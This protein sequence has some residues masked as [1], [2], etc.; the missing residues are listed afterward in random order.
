MYTSTAE[1]LDNGMRCLVEGLGIIE[2]EQ[3]VATL[4][5][6]RFDYTKWQRGFSTQRHPSR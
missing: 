1:V 5:R 3:F 4:K 2:A 6:E